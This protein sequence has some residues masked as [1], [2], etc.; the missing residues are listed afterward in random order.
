MTIPPQPFNPPPIPQPLPNKKSFER[1]HVWVAPVFVLAAVSAGY[2]IPWNFDQ[3][4]I[5]RAHV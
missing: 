1:P 2:A 3:A 4:K 5:G